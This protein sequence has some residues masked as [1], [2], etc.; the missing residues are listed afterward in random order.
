MNQVTV[1]YEEKINDRQKNRDNVKIQHY[2]LKLDYNDEKYRQK[3]SKQ[4][5]DPIDIAITE[6][7]EYNNT[8]NVTYQES[9]S[10][11]LDINRFIED[12]ID[13][14]SN[15]PMTFLLKN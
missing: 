8:T 13:I 1:S 3:N 12:N 5:T 7:R 6:E 10:S 14:P 11:I 9:D 15:R 4:L 2:P